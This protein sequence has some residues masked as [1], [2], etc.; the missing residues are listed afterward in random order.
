VVEHDGAGHRTLAL[1][2]IEHFCALLDGARDARL[3]QSG[4]LL[5]D[6]RAEVLIAAA[7]SPGRKM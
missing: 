3:D 1:R 2:A 5:V 6:D 4:G 7:N